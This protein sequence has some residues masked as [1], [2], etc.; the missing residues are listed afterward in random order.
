M[1]PKTALAATLIF[2][3]R[4]YQRY[5]SPFRPPSCRFYPSCSSYAVTALARFGAFK[6]GWLAIRRLG[7]C[8]PWTPGG[9]DEVP[10]TWERRHERPEFVPPVFDKEPGVSPRASR[11]HPEH[12]T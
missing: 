12:T 7:R 9:V 2:L 1:T 3:V 6:G 11:P 4:M 8:H 5:V 10:S